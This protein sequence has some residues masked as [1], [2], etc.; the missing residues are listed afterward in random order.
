MD[1]VHPP[2]LFF[3]LGMAGVEDDAIA[4]FQRGLQVKA[5]TLALDPRDLA[6]E[7]A[8]LLAEAGMDE[9]LIIGAVKPPGIEPA[10]EGHLHVIAVLRGDRSGRTSSPAR[11]CGLSRYFRSPSGTNLPSATRS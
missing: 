2:A 3:R 9:L 8:A 11:S 1:F 10:R 4:R 7:H 6:Q 5:D